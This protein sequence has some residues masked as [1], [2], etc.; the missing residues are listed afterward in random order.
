[1]T[2]L[3]IP[4]WFW[5]LIVSAAMVGFALGMIHFA[6]WPGHIARKPLPIWATQIIGTVAIWI[7]F[8]LFW[9]LTFRSW[10]A[11]FVLAVF[12]LFA[13]AVPLS[14][15]ALRHLTHKLDSAEVE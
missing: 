4:D 15:R 14:I 13:G 2:T 10:T 7:G 1:M 11:P 8:T 12:D 3:V 9:V 6:G 5:W